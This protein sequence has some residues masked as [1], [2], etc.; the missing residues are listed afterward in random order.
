MGNATYCVIGAGAAGL[1]AIRTLREE[2]FTVECYEKSDRVGGHWHDDYEALHLITPKGSSAFEGF[3]MPAEYPLYP[4]RDQVRDYMLAYADAFDL[5]RHIR[6]GTAVTHAVP[7]GRNGEAGW[8]VTLSTGETKDYDGVLVANGHLWDPKIPAVAAKFEGISIHSHDYMNTDQIEGR[9]LVVGFGNSGCDLA[10]DAAQH[11]F[12]V[13]IAVRRGQLFQPKTLMGKPRSELSFLNELPREQQN[14]LMNVLI[15][16]SKGSA[17]DYPGLPT[18]ETYDLDR[19]PPVVNDLLLYW[20]QHGRV[21]PVPGVADIEGKTVRFTDGTSGEYDTILW[22]T[23]FNTRL[24]FLDDDLLEWEAGVPL[25]NAG[26]ILPTTV[27]GLYFVGL[28]SPRGPQWPV[29]C[30]Q[31]RLICEML[32]TRAA[33]ID[34]LTARFARGAAP[35]TRIDIIRHE[36]QADMDES[37][38]RLSFIAPAEKAEKAA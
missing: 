22:A 1:A 28:C 30:A 18:P 37:W 17:G 35:E 8:R 11:R 36:W 14:M 20:I 6:L 33:G 21:K 16:A 12:D 32:R 27:E 38:R 3:P 9:V 13:S 10:V 5:K 4:S 19:Q 29:Y 31:S 26:T 15:Y 24:P 7:L 34:D 25:R 23:G 2:G